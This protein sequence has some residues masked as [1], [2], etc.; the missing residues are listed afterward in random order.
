MQQHK[1][2]MINKEWNKTPSDAPYV[3]LRAVT[4]VLPDEM[5]DVSIAG[6]QWFILIPRLNHTGSHRPIDSH[7]IP[8]LHRGKK[9]DLEQELP[10]LLQS[11][12]LRGKQPFVSDFSR[13]L[14][15]AIEKGRGPIL[16]SEKKPGTLRETKYVVVASCLIRFKS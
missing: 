15:H 9:M 8:Y 16:Y 2:N 3:A 4:F 1:T 10:S 12:E 6:L 7:C 13:L 14:R 11:Y 5:A